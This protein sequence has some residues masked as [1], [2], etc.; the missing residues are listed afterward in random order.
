MTALVFS[1]VMNPIIAVYMPKFIIQ[2]FEEGRGLTSLLLLVAAFGIVS[3]IVGQVKSFADGYFPRMK[4]LYRSMKL[5]AEMCM[6]SMHVH[7]KYLSSEQGQL[8]TQKARR[9]MSNT[10]T[11]VEDIVLRIVECS[12]NL[13]GALVFI[14]ILSSISPLIILGLIVCGIISF[15]AGNMVNKYRLKH[16][17]TMSRI[18]KKNR[19]ISDVSRDMKYGKDIRMYGLFQWLVYMGEK[20]MK[21]ELKWE[22]KITLRV[23]FS[24]VI[25]GLIA[26]LRDGF[27]YVYL[28]FLVV[29]GIIPVSSFILYISSIAGFSMWIS[30]FAKNA[31]I[32]NADSLEV[33][34]FRVLMNKADENYKEHLPS[35]DL[36]SP[37]SVEFKNVNF[38]YGENNIFENFSLKIDAGKKIALVGINGA[39]KTTLVKL[40]LGLVEPSSGQILINGIDSASI[41]IRQYYDQ[42]S[43]AFQ[44]ALILAFGIDV[45]I[46]MKSSE[47][48]DQNK[49]DEAIKLA[50]LSEKINSLKKGKYTSAEKYMDS[51]GTELSGG[52]RQKIILA[53]ALYKDA[54]I[55]VLDEPSSALDPIAESQLYEK[56]DQMTYN[57]TS[58]YISHRLASTK[59]CDEILLLDDGKIIEQ[60]TH[61]ELMKLNKQY[62]HMFE[63]QSHY[64]KEDVSEVDA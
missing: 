35:V 43:V 45:N 6:A 12:A 7:Y 52:E 39:G 53:R 47:L 18:Q 64:Y 22:Q 51:E 27:A 61:G 26:F 40:M 57:K 10:R 41:D 42:F 38:A 25:D 58:V 30:N 2:F 55:L 3:L 62:A 37:M 46:S 44:D 34:D 36:E 23:F 48:T 29:D 14:I 19:Y 33:S 49:V 54:P 50:G 11:G 63:V 15:A 1:M 32:L 17:D 56:Y 59:F 13:L 16:K 20:H 31:I 21:Q 28:I 5:G 9:A 4:S 24:E 60:G 8:E